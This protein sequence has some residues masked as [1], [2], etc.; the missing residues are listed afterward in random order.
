M[1]N[2]IKPS[3][4][5]LP[6]RAVERERSNRQE[7][8]LAKV[9]LSFLSSMELAISLFVIIGIASIIGTILQQN[10]GYNTYIVQFGP[11][12]FEVFRS[13]ELYDIYSSWWFVFL[14]GFLLVSTAT[15]LYHYIPVIVREWRLFRLNVSAKSLKLM[16]SSGL[17]QSSSSVEDSAQFI[18]TKLVNG[19]YQ[20]RLKNDNGVI[21]IAAKKGAVN[22]LGYIFTHGA[23][24]LICLSALYDGNFNLKLRETAGQLKPETRDLFASQVPDISRLKANENHA[25]RGNANIP[26]G[27]TSGLVFLQMRNGFL[28]Q[29]LPFTITLN[30]FRIEY[31]ESGM[32]KSFES[33]VVISDI[34]SGETIA[35]TIAVNHP[36][37]YKDYAI[38]Q[39]SFEDGGSV[40]DI[41]GWS[42]D[43]KQQSDSAFKMVVG[44]TRTITTG[45]GEFKLELDEFKVSNVQPNPDAEK[46]GRKFKNMGPS[47]TFRL[48]DKSGQAKEFINYMLPKEQEGR[49]FFLSGVRSTT[50]EPFRYL[51][52]PVDDANSLKRFFAFRALLNNT[53]EM[54]RIAAKTALLSLAPDFEETPQDIAP[55]MQ[56]MIKQM[57]V[58]MQRLA[59]LFNQGGFDQV[60]NDINN[61]VPED[62]RKDVTESYF[63]VLQTILGSVYLE[64]LDAEGV[65]I[66]ENISPAQ[67]QYY[68]D[69]VNSMGVV[70]NYGAPYYFQIK[71]FVHKEASGFQVTKSPGKNLVYLGSALLCIGIVLMFYVAHK[72]IWIIITPVSDGNDSDDK[73]SK[74]SSEILVAGSGDR[75]QKEFAMEFQALSQLLDKQFTTRVK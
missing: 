15:C 66:S 45:E 54:Q 41:Q 64:V 34:E 24:I 16:H 60:L 4:E 27:S 28:V 18:Q 21:T 49:Y 74:P 40:I 7:H 2:E 48:R 75:H 68:D 61:K 10:Q 71:S 35:K 32:P 37:I 30:D 11:F 59:E 44:D 3:N 58:V 62:K 56:N 9:I 69:L 33:D 72:R 51:F 19:G 70:G 1:S 31:Y 8:G 46:T 42:L 57:S 65:D 23:I 36:L 25:F 29:E 12:W 47:L 53:M 43:L 73:A 39:A 63:K 13:L 5:N 6:D 14:L 17:W 67:E 26:E 20:A 22:R 50:T 52:I 38:Y 55:E